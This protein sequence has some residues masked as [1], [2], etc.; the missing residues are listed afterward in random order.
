METRFENSWG[1]H[2]WQV[3]SFWRSSELANV[4]SGSIYIYTPRSWSLKSMPV[5][6]RGSFLNPT[7]RDAM[8]TWEAKMP[9][10]LLTHRRQI[11]ELVW[12]PAGGL[13]ADD[14][15]HWDCLKI[16]TIKIPSFIYNVWYIYIY[17]FIFIICLN[18]H[19]LMKTTILRYPGKPK[20]DSTWFHMI[21]G[22]LQIWKM[23]PSNQCGVSALRAEYPYLCL[24]GFVWFLLG[25]KRFP[26]INHHVS[27]MF[28]I[29]F[30]YVSYMVPICFP[31]V[32]HKTQPFSHLGLSWPS[33]SKGEEGAGDVGKAGASPSGIHPFGYWKSEK[34]FIIGCTH[35]FNAYIII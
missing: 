7:W 6:F 4:M 26:L 31:Y 2:A 35:L 23:F 27:H 5:V 20:S 1:Q 18:G 13:S 14:H 29:C 21:W 15:K 19:V 16:R 34:P 22:N 12:I 33:S 17:M 28:P 11:S 9:G 24:Y 10:P 3:K 8:K 25:M 30:P 32:S